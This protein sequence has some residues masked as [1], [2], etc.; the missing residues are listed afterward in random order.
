V[1][2]AD[3]TTE[4][5]AVTVWLLA[6][7]FFAA[8]ASSNFAQSAKKR[9]EES[10]TSAG[11]SFKGDAK[12]GKKLYDEHCEMCHY[13][14]NNEVKIGPG[15]KG[16]YRKG[17]FADGK[18]VDDASMRKWIELGGKDMPEFKDTLKSDEI[19]DLIAYLKTL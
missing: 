3:R 12:K 4:F 11:D 9:A 18:K 16:I 10:K 14:A 7:V 2:R 13:T 17:K 8:S 5:W 1:N 6:A 15:L 19:R